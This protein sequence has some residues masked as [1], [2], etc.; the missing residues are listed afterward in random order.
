M[1]LWMIILAGGIITFATR[2]SFILLLEKISMPALLQRA[3]RFVPVAVFSA[4]I[5][6]MVFPQEDKLAFTPLNP[7][8]ISACLAALVAWRTRNIL[9]T[10]LVGMVALFVFQALI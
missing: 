9:L 10:I 6:P 7:R 8:L 1:T 2:L 5:F 4:L 3:L